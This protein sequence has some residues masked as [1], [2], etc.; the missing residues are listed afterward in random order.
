MNRYVTFLEQP[1]AKQ[2]SLFYMR[3]WPI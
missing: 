1:K 2:V 3:A